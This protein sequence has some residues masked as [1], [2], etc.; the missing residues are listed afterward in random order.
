MKI[1]QSLEKFN[2][3]IHVGSS[4]V[5][6]MQIKKYEKFRAYFRRNIWMLHFKEVQFFTSSLPQGVGFNTSHRRA[7]MAHN[8]ETF[9]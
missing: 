1:E 5:H 8:Y 3:M 4:N 2:L 9:M 6:D 7:S